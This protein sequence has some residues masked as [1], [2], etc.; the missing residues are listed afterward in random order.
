MTRPDSFLPKCDVIKGD[1]Y[2]ILIDL[3]GLIK[4]NIKVF[5]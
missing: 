5:R 1:E 2:I 4:E 3:P